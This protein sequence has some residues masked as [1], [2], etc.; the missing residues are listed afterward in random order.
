MKYLFT[1]LGL[2]LGAGEVRKGAVRFYHA[3]AVFLLL[4]GGTGFV[5]GVND[6]S[7]KTL[8]IWHTLASASALDEPREGEVLLAVVEIGNGI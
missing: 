4:E 5:V 8:R 1:L 6:F 7:F 3:V 2:G